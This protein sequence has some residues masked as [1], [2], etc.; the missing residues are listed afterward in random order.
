MPD[1]L[2]KCYVSIYYYILFCLFVLAMPHGLQD[3]LIP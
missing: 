2:E 1:N 3:I